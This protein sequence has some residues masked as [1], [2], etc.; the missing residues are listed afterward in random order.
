MP[1]LKFV[2]D[3]NVRP[4]IAVVY[5]DFYYDMNMIHTAYNWVFILLNLGVII[6]HHVFN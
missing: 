1:Y 4:P 5:I 3:L 2:V 6:E